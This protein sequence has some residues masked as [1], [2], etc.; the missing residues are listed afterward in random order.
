MRQVFLV[1]LGIFIL[2][3]VMSAQIKWDGRFYEHTMLNFKETDKIWTEYT[4]LTILDLKLD[5]KP[6]ELL[7]VRSELEFALSH[8]RDSALGQLVGINILDIK[9]LSAILTPG[10]F[11]ITI[12]RFLPK[13]GVA[14]IFRPLDIF[15]PQTFMLNMLSFKGRDG[16]SFKFYISKMSSIAVLG[17]TTLKFNQYLL[18][19]K[20]KAHFGTFDLAMMY[21][22]DNSTAENILGASA[23]GDLKIGLWLEFYYNF[24]KTILY[25]QKQNFFKV[26]AG[27]DYSFAKYFFF[28]LEYFFDDSGEKSFD[29]YLSLLS[30]G[31][32][33]TF[34]RHY[35]YADF[36]V[37]I[38]FVYLSIGLSGIFNLIDGSV[39]VFPYYR[40]EIIPN[41]LLGI[42]IYLPTGKRN[43]EYDSRKLGYAILNTYLNIRF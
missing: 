40:H 5:V 41:C 22:Y 25:R 34:G 1:I 7:R 3:G 8:T 37:F 9:S 39:I 19:S 26:T 4:G 2:C 36:N 42:S 24:R 35:I 21:L 30:K 6:S 17:F 20:I 38:N 12:G 27:L 23:K 33:M 10:K 13:W 18:S 31:M 16:A 14:K 28:T 32:R 29:N 43:R 11:K 15:T